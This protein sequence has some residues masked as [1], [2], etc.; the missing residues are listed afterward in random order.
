MVIEEDGTTWGKERRPPDLFDP[1]E[2]LSSGCEP[3]S[4]KIQKTAAT[5]EPRGKKIRVGK[6]KKYGAAGK[7]AGGNVTNSYLNS[8]ADER[9]DRENREAAKIRRLPVTKNV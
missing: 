1:S 4:L 5:P 9:G 2:T 3:L 7:S 6:I 8:L